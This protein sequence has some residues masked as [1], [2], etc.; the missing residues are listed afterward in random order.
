MQ[1]ERKYG[2]NQFNYNFYLFIFS[3][4]SIVKY[5]KEEWKVT[6]SVALLNFIQL[7]IINIGLLVGSLLCVSMIVNN[8][9]GKGLTVGDYV[10]FTAYLMQLYA[11]LNYFGTYYR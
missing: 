8:H 3:R 11:P 10:M 7:I 9:D 6:A 2:T 1:G 4:R 5:Q